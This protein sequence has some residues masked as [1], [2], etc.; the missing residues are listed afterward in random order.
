MKSATKIAALV[1]MMLPG[2]AFAIGTL[3]TAFAPQPGLPEVVDVVAPGTGCNGGARVG[4]PLY[5]AVIDQEANSG[6]AVAP[7]IVHQETMVNGA[8]WISGI[9]RSGTG[10]IDLSLNSNAFPGTFSCVATV[11]ENTSNQWPSSIEVI[12]PGTNPNISLP[13]NTVRVL[14]YQGNSNGVF[15]KPGAKDFSI[16]CNGEQ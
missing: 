3:C 9:R 13:P 8:Y 5:T 1:L 6:S 11:V 16:L 12:T 4:G 10:S 7:S 14:T 2:A 15:G